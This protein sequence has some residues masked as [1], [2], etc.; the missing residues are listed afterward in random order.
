MKFY[1]EKQCNLFEE[2]GDRKDVYFAHCISAD[3][4]M[5]AGIAVQ[6]VD[7]FKKK[8]DVNLN[9]NLRSFC[10]SGGV[11][12]GT[13]IETGKLFNLVTKEN[14]WGKPTYSS[15]ERALKCMA[16]MYMQNYTINS[17]DGTEAE[18]TTI[19]MPRIGCG[20]GQLEWTKVKEIIFKVF[21]YVPVNIVVCYL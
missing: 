10:S 12:E 16:K 14:Y 18:T 1:I 3:C 6:F 5:G 11:N 19:V 8:Y 9:L 20:L 2:Y 15:L 21:K 13:C 7:W 17:M 4:A